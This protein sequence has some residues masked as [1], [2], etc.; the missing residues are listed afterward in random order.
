MVTVLAN[1]IARFDDSSLDEPFFLK[2]AMELL[3]WKD[4]EKTI[5]AK[6]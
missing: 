5:Y 3:Y 6:F 2:K 1:L 4:N